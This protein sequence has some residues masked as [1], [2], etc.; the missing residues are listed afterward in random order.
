MVIVVLLTVRR[1]AIDTFRDFEHRAARVMARYGGAIERTVVLAN[2][3]PDAPHREVHVVTFPS[4]NDF[5]E[6]RRDP[7]LQ[8]LAPLRAASVLETTVHIGEEGPSYGAPAS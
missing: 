4:A 7:T 2:D 6:Y 1:E 5:D 8:A 3:R